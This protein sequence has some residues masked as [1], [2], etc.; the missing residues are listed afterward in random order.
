MN[1]LNKIYKY[2]FMAIIFQLSS[3]NC[4]EI[5]KLESTHVQDDFAQLVI[6]SDID[7]QLQTLE[8]FYHPVGHDSRKLITDALRIIYNNQEKKPRQ[9]YQLLNNKLFT[10][11]NLN[12][13]MKLLFDVNQLKL[14]I[15][16]SEL[17]TYLVDL[18]FE[19]LEKS[20]IERLAVFINVNQDYIEPIEIFFKQIDE[21]F[22]IELLKQYTLI[23]GKI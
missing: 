4:N 1:L 8:N 19:L 13:S 23:F 3:L 12:D 15:L 17:S 11:L 5:L 16:F 10:D 21:S 14:G 7:L 22:I 9:I 6:P 20:I 18:N 2:I